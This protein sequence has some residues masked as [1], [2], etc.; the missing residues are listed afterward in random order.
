MN[1]K[2]TIAVTLVAC[3]V[4]AIAGCATG[5]PSTQDME[6]ETAGFQ[7]PKRPDSGKAMVYV[8][9][10][11]SAGKLIR[12][13]V[14]LDDQE[15]GSEMGYTRPGQY[16]HFS[17]SPGQH[18][19]YSKAENWAELDISVRAGE[20]AFVEQQPSI[21]FVIARNSLLQLDALTGKYHVKTLE[22]G[23]LLK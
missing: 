9:R 10:P 1:L 11:S 16:I 15:A 12:F 17:V 3:S 19:I 22:P 7:L 21:G 23:T 14:F 8:V 20:V 18:K 6:S 13:N 4:I 2:K 5:V